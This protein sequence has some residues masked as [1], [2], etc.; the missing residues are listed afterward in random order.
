MCLKREF[1]F[2]TVNA[3]VAFCC[4]VQPNGTLMIA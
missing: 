1:F 3:C 2:L 4:E